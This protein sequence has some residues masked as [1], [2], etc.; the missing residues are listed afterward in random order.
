MK[1][2]GTQY[3]FLAA[4]ISLSQA[5]AVAHRDLASTIWG[6]IES[7]TTCVGCDVSLIYYVLPISNNYLENIHQP[8]GQVTGQFVLMVNSDLSIPR[9]F[10]S[11]HCRISLND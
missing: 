3:L 6:D 7:D 5:A 1:L 4:V 10:D 8:S 11:T 9:F 2:F